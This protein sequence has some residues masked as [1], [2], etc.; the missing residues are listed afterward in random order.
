MTNP[1]PAELEGIRVEVPSNI[2]VMLIRETGGARRVI[3]IY[4]GESEASSIS[5]ALSGITPDRPLTHDL[6]L[7]V[8]Y[9]LGGAVSSVENTEVREHTYFANLHISVKGSEQIISLRPLMAA[10]LLVTVTSGL[11]YLVKGLRSP[12]VPS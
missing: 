9:D 8:V 11:D 7:T 1:I 10:A 12:R 4:I 6:L 5:V 3:P 2:P